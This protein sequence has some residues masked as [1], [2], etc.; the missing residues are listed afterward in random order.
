MGVR[1]NLRDTGHIS[2]VSRRIVQIVLHAV[3]SVAVVKFFCWLCSFKVTKVVSDVDLCTEKLPQLGSPHT[4]V[5]LIVCVVG[6]SIEENYITRFHLCANVS[7]P[8]CKSRSQFSCAYRKIRVKRVFPCEQDGRFCLQSPCIKLGL[9]LRPSDCNTPRSRGM[10]L[11]VRCFAAT[12]SSGHTPFVSAS[13][14]IT[15]RKSFEKNTAQLFS[16]PV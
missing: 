4:N 8:H 6:S 10:T 12:S 15:P 7:L 9:I 16:Q 1:S 3:Q 13:T 11:S 2:W 14:S 5:H